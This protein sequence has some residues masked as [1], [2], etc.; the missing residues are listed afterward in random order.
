MDRLR[1]LYMMPEIILM[2]DWIRAA[3]G[4]NGLLPLFGSG[5]F[6]STDFWIEI[7]TPA[8]FSFPVNAV[9]KA[10]KSRPLA[11]AFWRC[12]IRNFRYWVIHGGS[13]RYFFTVFTGRR[14]S[15]PARII[16]SK[17]DHLSSHDRKESRT[18]QSN[19]VMIVLIAFCFSGVGREL[20][21]YQFLVFRGL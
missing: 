1:S 17:A 6:E 12:R 18:D 15:I 16:D 14:M 4:L 19:S 13:L 10:F 5:Y 8:L 3:Q 20:G 11:N 9:A 21:R 7:F 2:S